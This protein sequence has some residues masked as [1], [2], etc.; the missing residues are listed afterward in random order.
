MTAT[1]QP[2]GSLAAKLVGAMLGS[3]VGAGVLAVLIF[4]SVAAGADRAEG[5]DGLGMALM[6]LAL[7]AL[8]GALVYSATV[9][10]LLFRILPKGRRLWP[11]LTANF[12][13]HVVGLLNI[14]FGSTDYRADATAIPLAVLIVSIPFVALVASAGI[15]RLRWLSAVLGVAV[16]V[17]AITTTVGAA[18]QE[19]NDAASYR[20]LFNESTLPFALVDGATLN[21]P[22]G[23][24]KMSSVDQPSVY[25]N[26]VS[27]LWL[28]P[29][30]PDRLYGAEDQRMALKF[31]LAG[32]SP[33][34]S[35]SS[36]DCSFE[37]V[38]TTD[39]GPVMKGPHR[40][41]YY[42]DVTGGRW[43][44]SQT[45]DVPEHSVV[46]LLQSLR[47]VSADQFVDACPGCG[48]R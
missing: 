31:A 19:K 10:A 41:D 37:Q 38:A 23:L 30:Y 27:V 46:A 45:W 9:T 1:S 28:E 18:H 42:V 39:H 43:V 25:R 29:V 6:G 24:W 8:L 34:C 26:E 14:P 40:A 22:E 7:A 44:I 47:P 13:P 35:G 36:T 5:W 20:Q 15:I 33:T 4:H 16:V 3:S 32:E 48:T 2:R 21:P 17:G 11:V 12:V